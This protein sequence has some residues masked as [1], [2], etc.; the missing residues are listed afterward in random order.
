M[1]IIFSYKACLLHMTT[2]VPATA[3]RTSIITT[4]EAMIGVLLGATMKN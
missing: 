3:M 1:N 2:I 4:D